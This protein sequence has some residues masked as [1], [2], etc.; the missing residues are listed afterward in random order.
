MK[1]VNGAAVD[2]RWE[3]SQTVTESIADRREGNY[4]VEVVSA[5]VDEKR[6]HGKGTEISV[7]AS[8][9]GH[10]RSNGLKK[11]VNNKKIEN[12]CKY[13]QGG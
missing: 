9:L 1:P 3:L 11:H 13:L 2:E 5:S 8:L 4:N 12:L 7:G 6:E 10:S